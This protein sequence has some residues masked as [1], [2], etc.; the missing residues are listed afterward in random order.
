VNAEKLHCMQC[1]HLKPLTERQD[2]GEQITW[3]DIAV[4]EVL[5]NQ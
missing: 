3:L 5:L 1:K 2:G 4:A